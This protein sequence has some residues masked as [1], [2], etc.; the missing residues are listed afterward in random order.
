[1]PG[2]SHPKQTLDDRRRLRFIRGR[3][4]ID[5]PTIRSSSVQSVGGE[6]AA[7]VRLPVAM[8]G[9][10]RVDFALAG[11]L[12]KDV[13]RV[14]SLEIESVQHLDLIS[15]DVQGEQVDTSKMMLVQHRCKCAGRDVTRVSPELL[16]FFSEGNPRF[17]PLVARPRTPD[18]R[19]RPE[20]TIS[21]VGPSVVGDASAVDNRCERSVT[22]TPS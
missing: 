19:H 17:V 7:F 3:A 13:T 10:V 1:M 20:Y 11:I 12:D 14:E 16:E 15:L 21:I 18:Y 5:T 22:D 8:V 4:D 6:L 2:F 9:Q